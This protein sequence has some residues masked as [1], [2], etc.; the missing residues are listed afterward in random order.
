M[1]VMERGRIF[2]VFESELQFSIGLATIFS[3]TFFIISGTWHHLPLIY[4]WSIFSMSSQNWKLTGL[5]NIYIGIYIRDLK[6]HVH[7][8]QIKTAVIHHYDFVTFLIIRK[9]VFLVLDRFNLNVILVLS[10]PVPFTCFCDCVG[11]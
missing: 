6:L 8:S 11:V 10:V 9:N 7:V 1:H 4:H 3:L 5:I 2:H